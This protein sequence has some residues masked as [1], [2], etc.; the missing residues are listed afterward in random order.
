VVTVGGGIGIAPVYPIARGYK[1]NGA[2]TINIIGA[3]EKKLLVYEEKMKAVSDEFIVCTDD[4]SHGRKALVT[5][6]L[7]EVLEANKDV[8]VCLAIGPAIMM[9]FAAETTRPFGVK[10]VVSLNSVMIDGTGMCGG[11]RVDIGGETFFT[12]VDGPEFDG[13]KVDFDLL[14]SRQSMYRDQERASFEQW[15]HA[16][17]LDSASNPS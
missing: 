3:R 9:K 11:C 13:H 4:G 6:P 8:E 12:C 10:T 1:E 5:E 17:K 14:M 15:Q 2:H 16:C 7:K